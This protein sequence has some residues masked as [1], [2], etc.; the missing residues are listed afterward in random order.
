MVRY[1][2]ESP[3]VEVE[4]LP[5]GVD[6]GIKELGVCSNAQVFAS[7]KDYW[8]MSQKLNRKQRAVSHKA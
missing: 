3:I 1:E 8:R 4:H 6:I 2:I 5:G 7:A